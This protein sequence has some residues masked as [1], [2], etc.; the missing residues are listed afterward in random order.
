MRI[1]L[2]CKEAITDIGRELKKCATTVH[3]QTMQNKYV[4]DDPNF[5]TKELQA[6]EFCIINTDD[7]DEMPGVTLEWAKDEFLERVSSRK[8]NPG[9][10]YKIRDHVWNQFLVKG[11]FDYTYNMR[12]A[13]QL[14]RVIEELE[15]HPET[16]Q[17]IIELH[18]PTDARVMGKKRVPC[19]MFYQFMKRDGKLDIIYVMRSSDFSTH[20][21]NDIWLADEMRRYICKFLKGMPIGKFIM[22]VSSLHIYKKDWDQL[23][24]Y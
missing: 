14:A 9:K 12:I 1:Y 20:F 21:Q 16:R 23:T 4:A 19:S 8:I 15:K 7:K 5:K 17:A 10:A 13:Y 24:N 6:F 18:Y 2:N 11:K 3:T 22:F